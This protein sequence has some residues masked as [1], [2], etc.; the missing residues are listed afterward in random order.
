MQWLNQNDDTSL[1]ILK[2]AFLRDADDGVLMLL[3]NSTTDL[4]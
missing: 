3:T 2:N 1:E 4:D